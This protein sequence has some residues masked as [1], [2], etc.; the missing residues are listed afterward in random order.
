MLVTIPDL[1]TP[2]E[3]GY[4]RQ[5]LESTSWQDG[6]TTAGDQAA[7]VKRNLQVPVD[8]PEGRE[9][10]NI[11]LR[12]LGRNP[13]YSSAALPLHVLPPMFNRYDEGMTFGAHVDGSIRVIPGT[14]QRIR[15][16][17]S[18]TIFLT[19]PEDY[20]G[21]E[22]VVHDT[23]GE[24]AVKLPAGHAVVYPATSLHSV[25]PVTRGSRWAS[26]FW[27]QSMVR[28]DWQRHM[29]YDLDRTIMRVRSVVP[30]DDPAA[31]GLTAHYHNLIRHWAEM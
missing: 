10:G 6:R 21:G 23:Y 13:A 29:L 3:V 31:T 9:L 26:F 18:T 4:I 25:T 2:E 24:H 1:L 11:V 8:S 16:D 7:L 20:D 17:V 30:D 19:P 27:A 15:T 28:D 12:A 22:L 14:A 5:V